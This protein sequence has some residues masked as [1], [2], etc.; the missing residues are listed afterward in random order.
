MRQIRRWQE[1]MPVVV[2]VTLGTAAAQ[3][4]GDH[5]GKD[6]AAKLFRK[7]CNHCHTVPD[8]KQELDV[9]WLDQ[10]NRTA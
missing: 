2:L 4:E 9:A 7:N 3:G 5:F 1:L 8:A 10:V 6:E